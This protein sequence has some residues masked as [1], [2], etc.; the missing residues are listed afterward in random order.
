MLYDNYTEDLLGLK[1]VVLIK[2][3]EI[4]NIKHIYLETKAE[5]I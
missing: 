5:A 2:I 4:E 1:G 3:K